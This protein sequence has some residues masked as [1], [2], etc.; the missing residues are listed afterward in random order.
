MAQALA[1]EGVRVVEFCHVVMG[2][3]CGLVLADM[4]AE[5]IK[6]EPL[7]G[8]HTRKLRRGIFSDL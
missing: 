8:D 7:D 1:L 3:A 2:P 5:V 4:G 6:V